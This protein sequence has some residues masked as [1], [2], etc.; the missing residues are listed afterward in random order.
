MWLFGRGNKERRQYPRN[1]KP[2]KAGVSYDDGKTL[3]PVKAVNIGGGGLCVIMGP[4]PAKELHAQIVLENRAIRFKAKIRWKKP[5][6]FEGRAALMVGL[7]FTAIKAD[8]WDAVM[9]WVQNEAVE[10]VNKAQAEIELKRLSADDA[11]RIIPKKML[12][13]MFAIMVERGRLAPLADHQ[14]PL[15][16]Y[17]YGGSRKSKEG[18]ETHTM[19]IHSKIV[20]EEG[21][22]TYETRF[23]FQP[24]TGDIKVS[25]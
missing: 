17:F 25:G 5:V 20:G 8:D 10:V 16:Q 19:Q 1:D 3:K 21:I 23:E 14:T 6:S 13:R 11:D 2:F 7:A 18:I 22:E 15:V 9:R 12:D 24:A 4:H